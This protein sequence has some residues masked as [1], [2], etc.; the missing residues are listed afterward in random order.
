MFNPWNLDALIEVEKETGRNVFVVHQL[1]YHPEIIKLREKVLNGQQDKVYNVEL[2]YI[3]PLG[4]WYQYSWKGVI[5]KSGGITTNI[6]I[7]LFDLLLWIFGPAK[8][9]EVKFASSLK[10]SGK[11]LL[12]KAEV[13]WLLSTHAEDISVDIEGTSFRNLA[14]DGEDIILDHDFNLLHIH[15]YRAILKGEGTRLSDAME[16]L[17]LIYQL[18]N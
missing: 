11:L 14:V 2:T 3:T 4:K 10:A 16:S 7:H 18:R 5:Q 6:G 1:C 9:N 15:V 8:K 17:K 13:N 12:Q